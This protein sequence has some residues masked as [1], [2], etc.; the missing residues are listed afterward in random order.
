MTKSAF[1]VFLVAA[2][3]VPSASF[4]E[5]D[6]GGVSR[7]QYEKKH[8]LHQGDTGDD[9][10][11][12]RCLSAWHNHPFKDKSDKRY[13]VMETTVKVMGIGNDVRDSDATSYPQLIL[14][15]PSVKVMSKQ[16]YEL[17]NPNGWYCFKSNVTV[18]GKSVIKAHCNTRI[19]DSTESVAVLGKNEDSKGGVTVLG[20]TEIERVGCK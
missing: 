10:A 5:G 6:S 18:M 3:S 1:P 11:I 2:L 14:I 8:V 12:E 20:K 16:T 19:A 4:A 15:K 7:E 13:R 9:K 17:M